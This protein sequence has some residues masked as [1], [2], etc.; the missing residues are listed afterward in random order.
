MLISYLLIRLFLLP[1]AILPHR[2]IHAIGNALGA[3]LYYL[4]PKFRKRALS[5]LALA[6]DLHL[7]RKEI[8]KIARASF[9]NLAITC[10]EYPKFSLSKNIEGTIICENPETADALIAKGQGIV[11]FVGHQAN[12]ETLFLDGTRRMPGVAIG[13]PIKNKYLYNWVQKMRTRFGGTIVEPKKGIGKGLRA[14]REGK[15]MGIVGDQALPEVGYLSTFLGRRAWTSPAPAILAYKTKSPLITATTRRERGKYYIHYSDPIWPNPD[16]TLEEETSRLMDETLTLFAA[17]IAENPSQWLWQ[18]NRWKQE[19]PK[20]VFYRYRHDTILT[21]FSTSDTFALAATL[22]EI[23]PEAFL[24]FL[25]P[26][27]LK[28]HFPDIDGELLTYATTRDKLLPDYDYKL[29]LDFTATPRLAAHYKRRA[30]QIV[31]TMKK[32]THD[33]LLKKLCRPHFYAAQ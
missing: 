18:H 17:S 19:T 12:W 6:T 28:D 14:L 15:F 9:Q 21:I 8:Q 3:L 27:N 26:E 13:R 10:L 1:F 20:N 23:Y 24:T 4:L 2:A 5:N 32:P 29:V 7:S 22:R 16:K 31:V 33:K 30:A 25:I 11:F